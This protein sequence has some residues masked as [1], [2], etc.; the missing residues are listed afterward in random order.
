MVALRVWDEIRRPFTQHVAGLSR[1]AQQLNYLN[2]PEFA[3]L[4]EVSSA[5]GKG[6]TPEQIV[7]IGK[8][9]ERVREWRDS[10]DIREQNAA[11]L[12]RL[13]DVLSQT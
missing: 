7:E 6:L 3:G 9:L 5:S 1:R 13:D 10:S 11:A 2:A 8:S 4:T 12:R